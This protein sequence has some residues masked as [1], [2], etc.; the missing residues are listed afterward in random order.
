MTTTLI[1]VRAG[2]T[3]WN[4]ENRFRGR[5]DLPMDDTGFRQAE[6]VSRR[7]SAE[8]QPA[9][10]LS[11]PLQRT[12]QTAEVIARPLGLTVQTDE[13]LLDMD[14]GDFA[15]LDPAEAGSRFADLYRA[16][17][18]VPQLVRLPQG[19]SLEDARTRATDLIQRMIDRYPDRQII[20]VSHLVICQ[21]LLCIAVHLHN[22]FV[23]YFQLDTGSL[24]VLEVER[25]RTLLVAVNDTCHL[26]GLAG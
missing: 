6:A 1:I 18:D 12:M 4:K 22:S 3:A 25:K 2:Q 10:V 21:M 24:S 14:Y 11:S 13:G 16:W 8:F 20:L 15:G 7:I 9:A 17:L 19:E 5:I 23:G 26:K